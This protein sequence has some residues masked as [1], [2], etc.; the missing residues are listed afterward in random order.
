MAISA[1]NSINPADVNSYK[2]GLITKSQTKNISTGGSS[3]DNSAFLFSGFSF[4]I[5]SGATQIGIVSVSFSH[6]DVVLRG[7]SD[8]RIAVYN[9]NSSTVSCTCTA[10]MLYT[11]FSTGTAVATTANGTVATGNVIYANAI[12]PW[13]N[14]QYKEQG[15]AWSTSSNTN[16]NVVG[17]TLWTAPLAGTQAACV[18]TCT[19]GNENAILRGWSL[20]EGAA[21]AILI[22]TRGGSTSISGKAAQTRL[23]L[24]SAMNVGG[25]DLG[26][27]SP[28]AVNNNINTGQL[29]HQ[30]HLGHSW[31][32]KH[33]SYTYSAIAR[34][35]TGSITASQLGMSTPSGYKAVGIA[36]I[37]SGHSMGFLCVVNPQATG[38]T[39]AVKIRNGYD[40]N[41]TISD[42]CNLDVLYM[43]TN[44]CY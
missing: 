37:Y 34:N 12:V 15:T 11:T 29:I 36:R 28:G 44:L 31:F 39:V 22:R 10:T 38:S 19:T 8:T 17:N 2:Y 25:E 6:N 43:S 40:S 3:G 24:K 14:K 30:D 27:T 26:S 32:I 33:Y 1:G 23:F 4:G 13:Y 5:P 18:V 16:I 20:S 21:A 35:S 42:T 9:L 41:N 7:I